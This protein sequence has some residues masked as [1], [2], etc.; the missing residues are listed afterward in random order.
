MLRTIHIFVLLLLVA[1]LPTRS[2]AA[3]DVLTLGDG[4]S[5][6][7]L[8]FAPENSMKPPPL[9]LLMTGGSNDEFMARAQYWLGK[10]LV[11]R[12]WALAVPIS[13]QGRKFFVENSSLMLIVI[14][15]L[16]EKYS[17]G[18]EKPLLV[19]ISS[20]GSAALAIATNAPEHYSG[21]IAAPGRIW[22]ETQ[23]SALM[24]LPI[25]LR[26]GEKDDFRWHRKLESNVAVLQ[27]AG[28]KVD[29]ALVPDAGHIFPLNWIEI[30]NWLG[31]LSQPGS[32]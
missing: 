19:G 28:A 14:S 3:E 18:D 20:G 13:D 11:D 5:I 24:D 9:A 12:G 27:D 26:I 6:R 31:N 8:F 10:E 16:R 29:A 15:Q 21:V 7:L 25:Y 22:D 30:E 1:L 32:R 4:V 17:V 23:F 2:F